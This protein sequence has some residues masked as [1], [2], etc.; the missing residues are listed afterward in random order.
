MD[1]KEKL[2]EIFLFVGSSVQGQAKLSVHMV[3]NPGSSARSHR[4]SVRSLYIFIPD[5]VLTRCQL[6]RASYLQTSRATCFTYTVNVFWG[7]NALYYL[8]ER[9]KCFPTRVPPSFF[10]NG[11]FQSLTSAPF[12]LWSFSSI[13]WILV[14]VLAHG[15]CLLFYSYYRQKRKKCTVVPSYSREVRSKT[16]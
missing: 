4:L 3:R 15:D 8:S 13:T 9:R 1:R 7:R 14:T 2:R 11:P 5:M 12:S 10:K 6:Y 16:P